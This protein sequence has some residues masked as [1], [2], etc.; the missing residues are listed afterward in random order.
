MFFPYSQRS[1][2]S[3]NRQA[4]PLV[5]EFLVRSEILRVKVYKQNEVTLID[6]GVHAHGGW[7]A[8]VLFAA[9]CL[10]GLASV[11]IHWLDFNGLRWPAVE[12]VTAH[13]VQACMASQY[14]GW[15]IKN[16][17]LLALGS[18]PGRAIIH[19]GSLY[20][21]LGYE[22]YSNMAILCLESEELPTEEIVKHILGELQCDPKNLYIL[23]APTASQVGSVQI[24][25]RA[26]ET[27]LS[28]LME[29]GYNLERIDSGWGT[30]P[31]PPVACDNISALGRSNDGILYGSTDEALDLLVKQ[32]PSC[33]SREYGRHFIEVY[34]EYGNFYKINPLVF[35]PA[36]VWL[37]N[38]NSGRS[39]HAG[40]LRPDLLR[41]SF[42]IEERSS[43]D[44]INDT[45]N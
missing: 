15:P 16:G 38:L 2:L 12:V 20:E 41:D 11:K 22:D 13:P 3:P 14:A 39:F 36:E 24:A 30:C 7:E 17:K 27:G 6:C 25:A 10:G 40:A 18:G 32:V 28:K 23:V 21:T 33:S 44:K 8:G 45:K 43:S 34:N 26:L 1:K 19:K 42:G 5:T 35:S 37:C 9:V 4:F 29:L 31:L